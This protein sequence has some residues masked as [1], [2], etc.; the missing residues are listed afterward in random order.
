MDWSSLLF[1]SLSLVTKDNNNSISILD[2]AHAQ[3]VIINLIRRSRVAGWI[4]SRGPAAE[5]SVETSLSATCFVYEKEGEDATELSD[6]ITME[7]SVLTSLSVT[8]V[9]YG[10]EGELATELTAVALPVLGSCALWIMDH[11]HRG[12]W[13]HRTGNTSIWSRNSP[14]RLPLPA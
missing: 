14:S 7:D 9:A 12:H 1:A 4:W 10:S 8:C 2:P 13:H 3:A 5:S 11:N 6:T